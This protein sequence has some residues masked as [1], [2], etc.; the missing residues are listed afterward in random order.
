MKYYLLEHSNSNIKTCTQIDAHIHNTYCGLA[1]VTASVSIGSIPQYITSF[2]RRTIVRSAVYC[3]M[4]V[5]LHYAAQP[6]YYTHCKR[7]VIH[8]FLFKQSGFCSILQAV[9]MHIESMFELSNITRLQ[10]LTWLDASIK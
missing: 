5:A 2:L 6:M 9:L 8:V 1:M 10:T 3:L 4:C 7:S